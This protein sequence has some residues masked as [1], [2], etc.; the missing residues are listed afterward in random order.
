MEEAKNRN[1]LARRVKH[2]PGLTK[3]AYIRINSKYKEAE[4][5]IISHVSKG[6]QVTKL[7]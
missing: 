4:P 5:R 3:G 7:N 6:K 2:Y 1:V